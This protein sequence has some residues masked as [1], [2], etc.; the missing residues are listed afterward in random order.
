MNSNKHNPATEEFV[1][2]LRNYEPRTYH[3]TLEQALS[4]EPVAAIQSRPYTSIS[5]HATVSE[6]IQLLA[7]RH[8]SCALVEEDSKLVGIFTDR[9]LLNRV[10]LESDLLSH[11]VHEVMTKNPVFVHD[12]D[13]SGAALCVMAVVGHRHVPVLDHD[14]RI[15]GIV[16]PQRITS[17]LLSHADA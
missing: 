1:D 4:E 2:P 12:T 11:P 13:S 6:A 14:H 17:F 10:A 5:P 15:I 3:N 16:T 7:S 9:D 8:V